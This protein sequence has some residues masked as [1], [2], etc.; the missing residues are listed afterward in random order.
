[1]A[2]RLPAASHLLVVGLAVRDLLRA[3]ELLQEHDARQVVGQGDR[4]ERQQLIGPSAHLRADAVRPA[5]DKRE[6]ALPRKRERIV[7]DL[8]S[9]YQPTKAVTKLSLLFLPDKTKQRLALMEEK[10]GARIRI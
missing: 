9:T 1:M 2:G 6:T 7:S 3:V 10:D 5:D 8:F 4:A